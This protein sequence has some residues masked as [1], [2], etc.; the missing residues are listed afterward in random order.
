MKVTLF[1]YGAGNL[2]SLA[3]ALALAEPRADVRIESDPVAALD[4]G[5]F[6]LPGVGAFGPA[7]ARL[8]PARE[9]V[10]EALAGGLP[11]VA[12]CLGMQLLFD[13]SDEGAGEGLGLVPGRVRALEAERVPHMGWNVLEWAGV[14]AGGASGPPWPEHGSAPL[15]LAYFAH[16][17]VCAPGDERAVLAWTRHEDDRF[18]SLVRVANT[19]GAQFHPEKSSAPGLA[20]LREALAAVTSG[21]GAAR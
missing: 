16:S 18:P 12:I 10:R 3:K 13:R 7:A 15:A 2:H 6:V 17:F 19:I 5:V 21:E 8:A 4:T 20:F 14:G 1:D 9:R 11:C